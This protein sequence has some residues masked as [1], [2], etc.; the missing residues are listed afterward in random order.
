MSRSGGGWTRRIRCVAG[1]GVL[2]NL[3]A[4]SVF[5]DCGP[6][7]AGLGPVAESIA[8]KTSFAGLATETRVTKYGDSIGAVTLAGQQLGLLSVD[9][10][11]YMKAPIVARLL[12][13]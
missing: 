5:Y 8:Y 1:S 4:I 9:G 6:A 7:S 13:D 2:G 3:S 12:S 10:R 11:I